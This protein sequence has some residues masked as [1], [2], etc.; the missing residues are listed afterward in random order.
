MTEPFDRAAIKALAEATEDGYHAL[1]HPG[2][3]LALLADLEEAE[4]NVAK[5]TE[6]RNEWASRMMELASAEARAEEAERRIAAVEKLHRRGT[7]DIVSHDGAT[8]PRDACLTC[9]GTDEGYTLP[10]NEVYTWP[11]A[12]V[13]ALHPVAETTEEPRCIECAGELQQVSLTGYTC[14][15]CGLMDAAPVAETTESE[16]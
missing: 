7:I 1:I 16:T 2:Q 5:I 13:A 10:P 12:T 14:R 6:N 15:A 3:V 4:R 8:V 9:T 11:C